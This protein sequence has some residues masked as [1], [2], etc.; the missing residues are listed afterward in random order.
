MPS[1]PRYLLTGGLVGLAMILALAVGYFNIRPA[2]FTPPLL[3]T[4]PSQPDFFM[5][6]TRI[7]QLNEAGTTA[8]QLTSERAVHLRDDDSTLLTEPRL[9][10]FRDNE[11]L[12]WLLQAESGRAAEG[13]NRVDLERNVVLQRDDPAQTTTRMNTEALTLFPDRDYAET[14]E[15]V[16]IEAAGSVTTATGMKVYLNDG[17]LELLST[18]RGQ[19]EAR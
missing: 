5:H 9:Q 19:H 12:P 10:F 11:P 8:Y 15:D 16:R 1:I 7:L 13:G 14:A 3:V 6:N 2:S 4:D 18:V 17:R